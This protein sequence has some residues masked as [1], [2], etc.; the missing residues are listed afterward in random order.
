VDQKVIDIEKLTSYS[1]ELGLTFIET[2][3]KE[4]FQ[5]EKAFNDLISYIMKNQ[6]SRMNPVY[7]ESNDKIEITDGTIKPIAA[8]NAKCS[9]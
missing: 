8:K 4:N 1:E 2:S 3:A 9:C 7:L 5:V 6:E